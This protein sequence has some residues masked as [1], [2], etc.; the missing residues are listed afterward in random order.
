MLPPA[1]CRQLPERRLDWVEVV[2]TAPRQCASA[3][4]TTACSPTPSGA[5]SAG[6]ATSPSGSRPT[7]HE[8]TYLTLR[9]WPHG[10][11]PSVPGVRVVAVGPRHGA[12]HGRRAPADPAAAACSGSAC[13][14][15]LLRHG[16]PLRRRAHLRRSPTSRCSP[17]RRSGRWRRYRLV[18]DWY[19]VWSARLLARVPGARRRVHRLAG[20]AAC[21]RV[22]PA[23]VLLLATCTR[24]RLREEG[25][26]GERDGARG[27]YAGSARAPAPAA[28]ADAR[29]WCSPAAT[30]PRSGCRRWSPRD[31][32]A[33][34][35]ACP[36]CAARSSAT[37][38]S[39][40]RCSRRSRALG[41]DGR[42]RRRPGF[43]DTE[44]RRRGA[45]HA[46]C[47]CVLP[48]RRE[49][50][51]LVVVEA[52]AR[53]TPSVVVAGP[54]NAAVEL[55]EEGVNGFVAA[56]ADPDDARRR[57]RA[58]RTT[59]G[60]RCASAPRAWFAAQRASGCRST[61]SLDAVA[62]RYDA[63]RPL[64]ARERSA[65]ARCAPR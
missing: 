36:G 11:D 1:R 7:G 45:A 58:R 13:S 6:T 41:L 34:A 57:D 10:E 56:S 65:R 16:A 4:S 9:Q 19:E 25:L 60:R 21:L 12:L 47:A 54:D 44:E 3:S 50:Y 49:G 64:V 30:S 18:V 2:L 33:R 5:P 53:G 55:I 40:R 24:E 52:A 51:G 62:A 39:A 29:S 46:R 38:R 22:A 42:R 43:V 28:A 48:S 20:P 61:H 35:S 37:G 8:V 15:H 27:L 14:G 23:R 59:A 26:R 32:R 17:R 31:R 63:E